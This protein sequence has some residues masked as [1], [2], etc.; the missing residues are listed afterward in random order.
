MNRF[1]NYVSSLRSISHN[2]T[3]RKVGSENEVGILWRFATDESLGI[4]HD[5]I[6]EFNIFPMGKHLFIYKSIQ[7]L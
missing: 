5:T 7:K 2:V 6:G 4:I 1:H 3:T